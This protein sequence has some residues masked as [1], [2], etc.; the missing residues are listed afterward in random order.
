MSQIT[1]KQ[2]ASERGVSLQRVNAILKTIELLESVDTPVNKARLINYKQSLKTVGT[3]RPVESITVT[4][5][6]RERLLTIE[7]V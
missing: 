3:G 1:P 5:I 6:G 7:Y 4:K 2:Y